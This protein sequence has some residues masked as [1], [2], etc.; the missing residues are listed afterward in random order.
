ML[1]NEGK[2]LISEDEC[3][4]II[5]KVLYFALKI[6]NEYGVTLF[7]SDSI[8]FNGEVS[9][10][11]MKLIGDCIGTFSYS[12][13]GSAALWVNE[14][15]QIFSIGLLA[16]EMLTS[17]FYNKD[18]KIH[19]PFRISTIAQSFII[20]SISNSNL[21]I[22]DLMRCPW[23]MNGIPNENLIRNFA[24]VI[25]LLRF[26]GKNA[27]IKDEICAYKQCIYVRSSNK[28]ILHAS[29]ANN[30]EYEYKIIKLFPVEAHSL[31]LCHS[32]TKPKRS[33]SI[34]CKQLP[35]IKKANYQLVFPNYN[36]NKLNVNKHSLGLQRFNHYNKR[37]N[38]S[39]KR[40][41]KKC[42]AS[43]CQNSLIKKNKSVKVNH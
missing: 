18:M 2:I 10:S 13:G 19:I 29:S 33:I 17:K 4:A 5:K 8:V 1:Q 23:I 26:I 31:S 20:E 24:S 16:Y 42:N 28:K 21:S 38:Q 3:K 32:E 34:G 35:V 25:N 40:S 12:D 27:N 30:S 15:Q 36:S 37:A 43:L 41:D 22:D 14:K 6:R 39:N 11:T 7:S 9:P